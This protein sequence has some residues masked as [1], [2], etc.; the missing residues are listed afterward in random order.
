MKFGL[1][2]MQKLAHFFDHPEKTFRSIH[3]AGTNGKGSVTTKI[4]AGLEASGRKTGLFTSPHIQRYTERIQINR[5]E[6]DKKSV[7]HLM[8]MLFQA[9]D[10]LNIS[11]TFFEY[12]TLLAFL[13]FREQKVEDAVI[14]TGLGGRLDATNIIH[15]KLAI[16]T[17][18]ALDHT[19]ILGDTIEKI[20][21]EKKGIVKPGVPVI[22]GPTVPLLNVPD[23]TYIKGSF[24]SFE[25]ENCAIAK[26]AMEKLSLPQEAIKKGLTH[27][28]PCRRERYFIDNKEI[29]LDVAH[30]PAAFKALFATFKE[31]VHT[32][33]SLNHT[34]DIQTSLKIITE[35]SLSL[36]YTDAQ[37]MAFPFANLPKN[38]AIQHVPSVQI[39]IEKALKAAA[40][41]PIVICGTFYIMDKAIEWLT[42]NKEICRI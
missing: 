30:N 25:E 28:P 9:A 22:L 18:I 14:E 31:P 7:V 41:R 33:F 6:I 35:N 27:L 39:G 36:F 10:T 8:K 4:A 13:Y 12:T 29:I 5:Q 38:F 37:Y 23:A 34:K 26:A 24:D 16:I 20:A 3:V 11:P 19:E 2:N 32:I 21:E 1:E 17:S 40:L 15:P 42:K